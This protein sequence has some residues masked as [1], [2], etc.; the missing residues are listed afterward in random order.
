MPL[1]HFWSPDAQDAGSIPGAK[2]RGALIVADPDALDRHLNPKE[3]SLRNVWGPEQRVIA[4]ARSSKLRNPNW[5]GQSSNRG[6][7]FGHRSSLA[8]PV[9]GGKLR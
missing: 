9:V 3:G 6:T 8:C 5:F 4:I 7:Q 2:K 1:L